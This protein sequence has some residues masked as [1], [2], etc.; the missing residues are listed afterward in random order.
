[1]EEKSGSSWRLQSGSYL[2]EV[3]A[4]CFL[5]PPAHLSHQLPYLVAGS[6]SQILVYEL[7]QGTMLRSL[8]VF[9]GIRVQGICCGSGAVIGDDGSIGFDM[10]VF[11]ERRV[12]MFR[13]EIDLGQQQQVLDVCLRLLQLLPS[14]GNW[15]LDVSFIKHGGGECVAVGCSDNSVHV[16]DVASCNVV[17]HVQHPERTLLYSM[18]LWGETLEALRIASGTIYNQIIVW[19]VAPESEAS[20]L[21]SQVEHRIDQSNSL[22]NG[23][24]L[25][26]CQYEVIHISKLAGHEGS[27]FRLSWSSNGSKLVSVSDDRSARVWAVCTETKHSKKPADSIE[28]MLFGHSARV[29]DCCILGSLIVTAGED[30]TCRV[31]G[32]DGKHLETIKEH[33]GR[34]IWRCLY[35]PKSSLLITAGF[36][37][38]IKVHQLHI[39]Y[40]GGL[41]GLAE[42]KQIDGI[43]T[44][45]TRIPTLCENIGPMDSKSEYV[46]CLRFTCEDTLYVATNHGYLYHAKLLDTGEVEWTK[47]V[48]VSDEVPIVCMDLLS[49]S[50]NLSSGVKD[51]IA[52]G[53][54]KGNMT[55]VGVMYGAS[56]P[57]VGFAFTWSAGKER[58][59]LGA[60][61]CQSVGYG[62]IFTADHRGTLKL[63]SLC[64]CSA[65]SCDVSLLAE[66]TSSFG[67][68]IM[69]LD[70][71]LE[72]EVL[73]CGDIRGNLLLFPLLKSV[74]LG[75]LVADDNISPSSCFK[76]AHGISSISSVAVGRLSSNQI[77]IC[78]T[79]ADGC[80][81]YLEYDKDRKDL[82]FIGMKQVKELSLIQSVSACNSSVTKLSNSRYAAGFASVD[83]I[84]WN[85]LT[86][87][88]VIQI[89][90]G[91][92]R[93]PHSYYLGDVPEIKNCF[94]YVKDDIIY[95]H[96]HWVLDG[97][98]KALS[99]N[100][101]MQ[102]HG[103][104][105]HSI[106]FV[107][108]EL[109]HGVIGKDRLSNR[110]SWIATGC[111]DGTVRLT[112]YMPG[113][114]NWSGSKLLGEHVGGSAVRS[115]CSVSKINILPSDMTSYLNMRT[116][117]NEA[118]EN[119]ETPALLISVGAKRVLTSWLLRNRKVDKKEEIVCDLQHDNTGNGNTCLSPESPSMS[120]QWLSTDMPAKYSSIQKVP[121]I[122]KRVDQAGDVSDGK[123]AASEK[124]NKELNLIKDKYEDDWRYMAVTAFLV[125]CV[126]SRI[127]VCFIG[128]A[129]SDA[130]LALRALVLPYRLWFDVAFLCP[131]SSPVLSLQHVILPACL[132]SEGNWQIGSLYILISGATDG[133]IA[134]W[135]LT[136]SI[137]AFMQ[138]VS[139]LDVEKFIDCQKRPR[140][141]RGSQGGRWWRSL[142]SSMSRNRQGASSTAVKA[143]VGTDEK[144]KHSG[145]SSM[146]NDHGSSRTASSHATHTASLD[147]ETSAYDSS[148]DICEIS[149]LF[150]FKA[151]H[152]SGVNSLYVSDVEGCQ[153][154]EIGFL[155][156][157]ISGGDD[158]ALSCLTFE[159]SVST[160]SSEFDNMTLE[161]KN[162]IS[163]SG[164][165]KKLIHCNQDKNYWIRF[166]NHDKV[167]SAH[168]SAVKGVWTDGSWVF[169]TGLDQRVRCWRLQ[170]E[171]K[172]IEY[173]Y[174]VISVPE[175][176]ALDAKLCGRNKYQ[177]AVAGRG[178]QMLEFSEISGIS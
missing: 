70:A 138:L 23:V 175:P 6:G 165:A 126:N 84:I 8:D 61:W 118:T 163:E 119:R 54:G 125:K 152:L 51:W 154:P 178:M 135:D 110:S 177:I 64:H 151:I 59:L 162:S 142:G 96:R 86:E 39:S 24:Q 5:H 137:E 149:P 83:F 67:S 122:E 161:I 88:K 80:I 52:V 159:L 50:F 65:K 169:S 75:T 48:R 66:F 150:V 33:T 92:W 27:I 37:S 109:Q 15:V 173:A 93:R 79:G 91:G 136:K 131:L 107:S 9:Q 111:E 143:G 87:T 85:L 117:D 35:D 71:S 17:L 21:T 25:P 140:T 139:V 172:L 133:S 171:G 123:D 166:L 18:R 29:W 38:A 115:I 20:C 69:C 57:K 2:G 58:Q 127:T 13:L 97:D 34:G 32:L 53:D 147:S 14:F 62:Y 42:T 10:A 46:R 120:F 94:A 153:S 100:L 98:R 121:N 1:M 7:E 19:K 164:N 104:E 134:F 141:G 108:E 43:F 102:F 82:E 3:S 26:N 112:R 11:G 146:L 167:P 156:N 12:K 68:R 128:V 113:V 60:H 49:E 56:A 129:C 16:W 30:C 105:M 168:S 174:L 47:L 36:D 55:V 41:D 4:L 148:S 89:P 144:P 99:R 132:P 130:T 95:I 40:S 90:C 74:L 103:R 176:E 73:V 106:C 114:E 28:L 72:E 78:S 160:S 157:L 63:W 31:W 170:E 81:C 116:R 76:G 22:S 155:Y 145:T 45:T 44:Y 101:H 158:Q 77:E 124:G